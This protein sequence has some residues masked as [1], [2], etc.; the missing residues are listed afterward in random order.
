MPFETLA[1]QA[2]HGIRK[3]WLVKKPQVPGNKTFFFIFITLDIITTSVPKMRTWQVVSRQLLFDLHVY[4][5]DC[6]SK[7]P[8]FGMITFIYS[9]TFRLGMTLSIQLKK[10]RWNY[11]RE[12]FTILVTMAILRKQV[13]LKTTVT[14]TVHGNILKTSVLVNVYEMLE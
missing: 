5:C 11:W 1:M 13:T 12:I 6:H 2:C 4:S 8:N 10:N 9:F 7:W 3:T 14:M